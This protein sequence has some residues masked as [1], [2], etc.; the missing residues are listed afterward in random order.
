MV[1]WYIKHYAWKMRMDKISTSSKG[2]FFLSG[3]TVP[4]VRQSKLGPQTK[5]VC[6][7]FP[8]PAGVSLSLGA[9][10]VLYV[11][12]CVINPQGAR[13]TVVELFVCLCVCVSLF[14]HHMSNRRY[15]RT[16][17]N[18]RQMFKM[19]FLLFFSLGRDLALLAIIRGVEASI[20]PQVCACAYRHQHVM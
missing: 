14:S 5:Y 6:I 3:L 11:F 8:K 1:Q 16:Q 18:K 17:R 13:V 4:M 15:Q 19:R 2:I 10:R 7:N 9:T 12:V 20:L